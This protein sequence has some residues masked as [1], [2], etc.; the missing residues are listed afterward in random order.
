MAAVVPASFQ[1][2]RT[3]GAGTVTNMESP[4]FKLRTPVWWDVT[5]DGHPELVFWSWFGLEQFERDP[6]SGELGLTALPS[7]SEAS[8]TYKDARVILAVVDIDGDGHDEMLAFTDVITVYRSTPAGIDLGV[9]PLPSV[10][11]NCLYDSASGDLNRDGLV[12]IY[13]SMGCF[14]NEAYRQ[15]GHPDVVLMNRGA[16]RFEAIELEPERSVLTTSVTLADVDGDGWLD[17]LESVDASWI[18]GHSRLLINRTT[19]GDSVPSFEPSEHQW[20]IG[21]DGMGAALGDLNGDGHLDLFNTSIGFDL[22][23]TGDGTGR[24]VDETLPRGLYHFWS[25]LGRRSQ[26]SPTFVDL[27]VDGR[28]DLL[29]RHGVR[30]IINTRTTVTNAPD[31]AYVQE[32]DGAMTRVWTPFVDATDDGICFAVGDLEGDG[33]PDAGRDAQPGGTI[34]WA[35]TT[36]V[37]AT[38]R[39]LTVRPKP[40]V[41]GSPATGAIVTATCGGAALTRHVTSGGKIGASAAYEAHFAWPGCANQPVA[42]TVTW[43]SGAISAH[44][45]PSDATVSVAEEPQWFTLGPGD[46]VTLDPEGAGAAQACVADTVGGWTCCEAACELQRPATGPG[47]VTLDTHAPMTLPAREASWLLTT[48]PHLPTPGDPVTIRLMHV[49][50]DA[51]FKPDALTLN[52]AGQDLAWSSTDDTHR[53]LVASYDVPLDAADITMVLREAGAEVGVWNRTAGYGL[54]P[55]NGTYDLYPAK[56]FDMLVEPLGW[57]VHLCA[58][59]GMMDNDVLSQLI[60]TTPEGDEVESTQAFLFGR[61]DRLTVSA[62]WENLVGLDTVLVRD[63][64][65][66]WTLEL[67]VNQPPD[68][69]ALVDQIDR[70][71]CGLSHARLRVGGDRSFGALAALDAAGNILGVS[72]SSLALRVEGGEV[73]M[74]LRRAGELWDLGFAIAPS[75]AAGP[76]R[77]IVETLDGTVLGECAFVTSEWADQSEAVT[78]HWA[79]LSKESVDRTDADPTTRLRVGLINEYDE[80]LGAAAIPTV[81]LVGGVWEDPMAMTDAGTYAGTIAPEPTGDTIT[82]TVTLAGRVLETL[83]VSVS[84]TASAPEDP[85]T[86][87]DPPPTED[88]GCASHSPSSTPWLWPLALLGLVALRQR[89]LREKVG[90]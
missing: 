86:P 56:P 37:P 25:S 44:D 15:T 33:I 19:P 61:R 20:D 46:T 16:G 88:S 1:A 22:L 12:D 42:L 82:V 58:P 48:S 29:I 8:K 59:P 90:A 85:D 57:Q 28:M 77:V 18:S 62:P 27:N 21:T 6:E 53:A 2:W 54:D 63:H 60:L 10:A 65:G 24:F 76:G 36:E 17:V 50:E 34:Y 72:A 66:G 81:L 49:G 32:E 67:P 38:T 3:D 84:G 87:E 55:V 47:L 75:E 83:T 39:L 80:L 5:Q 9:L 40:T 35:N 52:V 45:I 30:S 69:E 13:L 23:M 41:S 31:L 78:T 64:L 73:V 68:E 11:L 14:H 79:V 51:S 71:V 4:Y 7:T 26:W 74:D 70:V 89:R 43:P